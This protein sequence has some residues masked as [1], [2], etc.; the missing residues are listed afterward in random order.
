MREWFFICRKGDKV[1]SIDVEEHDR[2]KI[3]ISLP[4]FNWFK[5][6]LEMVRRDWSRC[7]GFSRT[8]PRILRKTPNLSIEN[9][10]FGLRF[11]KKTYN[12][13]VFIKTVQV[14]YLI[15]GGFLYILKFCTSFSL[16]IQKMRPDYEWESP[17]SESFIL[18]DPKTDKVSKT[19]KT[20]SSLFSIYILHFRVKTN[21]LPFLFTASL[22]TLWLGI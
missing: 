11:R 20:E 19:L 3:R 6:D 13:A 18:N 4:I 10:L 1:W 16:I 14:G 12:G 9:T 17:D 7:D 15:T 22:R 5:S 8:K 2:S 21:L